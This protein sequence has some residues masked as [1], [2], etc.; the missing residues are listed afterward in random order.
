MLI[1]EEGQAAGYVITIIYARQDWK[2]WFVSDGLICVSRS[3]L[4]MESENAFVAALR[5][6]VKETGQNYLDNAKYFTTCSLDK[7]ETKDLSL[8][9][10]KYGWFMEEKPKWKKETN[11]L[12]EK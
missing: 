7:Y 6:L 11:N 2:F 1:E 8:M 4:I 12:A 9:L 5:T 10:R 3:V